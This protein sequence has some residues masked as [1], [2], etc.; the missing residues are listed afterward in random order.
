VLLESFDDKANE[1]DARGV[2]ELGNCGADAAVANV[3]FTATGVRVR[4]S[5]ITLEKVLPG[6]PR[7]DA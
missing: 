4:D 7:L 1:L 5:P 6:L 3:V 2:G